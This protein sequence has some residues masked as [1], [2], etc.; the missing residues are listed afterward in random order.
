MEISFAAPSSKV[1]A[2][3]WVVAAPE[4]KVLT[5]AAVKADKASAGALTRALKFSRFAGKAGETL[6]VVA[7]EASGVSRLVLVGLGKPAALDGKELEVIGAKIV[8][9]LERLGETAATWE[10]E[11]PKGAKIRG[12][13]VAAHLAFGARL[14][15]YSFD[16]YR[17]R[18]LD[19]YK[20]HLQVLKL[21]TS[22]A[23][24]ARKAWQ[25][26]DA[27]AD[28]VLFARDLVN[29][30][31]NILYP[32]E[33]ARRA[34]ALSKLGIKVEVLGE[35]E[36]K[37][38]G[39][40]ALLGVGQGSERESQLVV[41]QWNGARKKGAPVAFV[42]KGVCFDTGGLSLKPSA[43]M[44]GMKGDMGGAAA[45]TGTMMALAARKAKVNA[46]GVIGLVENMPDGGAIRPDDVL[47]SLSGQ[48]IEVLNTDA[49]GRL[50]LADALTYTQRRFKPQFVIDLAT[51]TGAIVQ[52]LGFEHAGVFS[53]NER[54]ANRLRDAGR[55]TGERVWQL[56][57]DPA[58]DK[59]IRSKI[60][61]VKNIGGA[62]SG[63]ITAAQFLKRFIEEG[64]EWAHLDIAG[65]AWQDGEQK[66]M[67]PS[68]GTGWGVK[69][70]DALVRGHYES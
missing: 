14:R 11:V 64:T 51:L 39:F 61:D 66:P 48:T 4:G 1:Q 34:K 54:L 60:A 20:R 49:E 70:L 63:S 36:M 37:K 25:G 35:A 15:G 56:P 57:L 28:G 24:G 9:R 16:K 26:L 27:V 67:I 7:P 32:A 69:L 41:M 44:M 62:N 12:G 42:G 2:G 47:T 58:Y 40:G 33:F 65:V 8:A 5:P 55:I 6:D 3:A 53:N 68:W 23:A 18:N 10:I 17:T 38:Q 21:A 52:A 59:M 50:V 30:P 31:P 13:E 22:D 43:A 46:V 19:E 29:E 45:V